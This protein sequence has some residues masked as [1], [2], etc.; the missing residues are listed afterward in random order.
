MVSNSNFDI[1]MNKYIIILSLIIITMASCQKDATN[2]KL[3]PA[4]IQLVVQSFISPQDTLI[5]VYVSESA[6]IFGHKQQNNWGMINS[7]PDAKVEITHNSIVYNLV[8]DANEQAY[9]IDTLQLKI[10][11]GETYNIKVSRG[12]E[13]VTATCTV[14]AP[15]PF[16]LSLDKIELKAEIDPQTKDT[17]N[18][19][20]RLATSFT[21]LNTPTD[22]Y[23]LHISSNSQVWEYLYDG[24]GN[25]VDSVLNDHENYAYFENSE[26]ELVSD[27]EYQNKRVLQNSTIYLN[28]RHSGQIVSSTITFG[29]MHTDVNYY[30]YHTSAEAHLR[31]QGNPFAEPSLVFTN[32]QGGLGIFAAYNYRYWV[33]K[34]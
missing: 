5:R 9:I 23:R 33:K 4:K 29:M 6:P 26:Q 12:A 16:D 24:Q 30:K 19:F 34:L 22:Y 1:K 7:L 27:E 13:I 3:P 31:N 21:D 10:I 8:F 20:Y 11:A 25:I 28:D 15:L 2:V 14:P 17:L 18:M 32:I